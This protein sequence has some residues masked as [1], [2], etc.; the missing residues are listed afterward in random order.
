MAAL[1]FGAGLAVGSTFH[2]QK[3]NVK[4][5]PALPAVFVRFAMSRMRASCSEHA[6]HET[7]AFLSTLSWLPMVRLPNC[8]KR[9]VLVDMD[10]WETLGKIARTH[11][12]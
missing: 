8:D 2:G 4:A 3:K 5:Q 7:F 1:I 10:P 11:T 6:R 12:E 9:I